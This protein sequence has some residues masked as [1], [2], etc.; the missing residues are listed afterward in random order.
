MNLET[1]QIAIE[2]ANL[3]KRYGQGTVANDGINL[4]VVPGEVFALLGHNGAGKTTLVRQVTGELMPTSG[5]V[6]VF[7]VDVLKKP[8]EA[9]QFLGIVPQEV[10]LFGHLTVEQHLSYFGRLR[11]LD[12]Q[13]MAI[14]VREL[15]RRLN[16]V[17]HGQKLASQLS[18]GLKRKLLVAMAMIS[19]PPA[20]IL[21]EPTTGLDPFS[22]REVWAL[23][24]QYQREGTAV[25][26]TTHY[27]DE[28]ESL[29]D[30]VGIVSRGQLLTVGTVEELH[31]HISHRYKLTHSE[32]DP[33]RHGHSRRV[34]VYGR[35]V[36]ELNSRVTEL[37][38]DEY[39]VA[40]TSLEDIYMELAKQ[41][42]ATEV[43]HD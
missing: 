4:R 34:T 9:R 15:M 18:G 10:E 8:R 29:S 40:R 42:L 17:E 28:A 27:M 33:T 3:H 31:A 25:L 43:N 2:V 7:G 12:K 6:T 35:T 16:L 26:L 21:D 13:T 22:R 23:I 37:G 1:E 20:L 41:P 32:P 38:L 36:D 39:N 24:R 14:R 11:G 30:R 5:E 19:S